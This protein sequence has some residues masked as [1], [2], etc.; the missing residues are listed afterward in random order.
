MCSRSVVIVLVQKEQLA[1]VPLIKDDDMVKTFPPE[2]ANQP[3]RM[4]IL[5][6]G[7]R[8]NGPVPNAHGPKPP[9]ENVAVNSVTIPNDIFGRPVPAASLGKLPCNP[10]GTRMGR[11]SETQDLAPAVPEN[12]QAIK[13][14]KGDCRNHEE[15]HRGNPFGV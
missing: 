13:Q 7:A 3:L 4:S 8:R 10:F 9:G 1:Q 11:Y 2:R 12:Q 14:P 6:G 15:I 5:P